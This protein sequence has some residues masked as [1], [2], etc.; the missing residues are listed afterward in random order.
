MLHNL[1][2]LG[3]THMT[4]VQAQSLPS[5]LQ[6]RDVIAQAK[7]GSG[8]TVAFG[9]GT[10]TKLD[11]KKHGVQ[12]MVLCPTR[13]LAEQVATELRRLAR[14]AKNIKVLTLCGGVAFRPQLA[15]LRHDAHV[16]V[17]TPGRILKHLNRGSL[18]LN[19]SLIHI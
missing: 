6:N 3:F 4:P 9:I 16:V 10:L 15:S 12:S 17:G 2:E 11:V 13:E 18:D 19:L 1:A 7:T 14:F 5:I 8:K